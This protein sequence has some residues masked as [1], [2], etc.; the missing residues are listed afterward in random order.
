[1]LTFLP[2]VKTR[3]YYDHFKSPEAREINSNER[4][5]VESGVSGFGAFEPISKAKLISLAVALGGKTLELF[6]LT[7]SDADDK[8]V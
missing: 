3:A 7:L 2:I 1:M 4:K 6:K 5:L 8:K